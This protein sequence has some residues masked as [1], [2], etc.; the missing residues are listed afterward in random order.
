MSEADTIDSRAVAALKA[1]KKRQHHPATTPERVA[2]FATVM[3]YWP[4]FSMD[5]QQQRLLD[6]LAGGSVTPPEC[7][8][9]LGMPN[10]SEVARLLGQQLRQHGVTIH[11]RDV[12]WTDE[13]GNA[14]P[15]VAYELAHG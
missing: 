6:V 4:G 15:T 1:S 11:A 10:P 14:R 5:D 12:L 13:M 9:Y 2:H 8:K 7:R 3:D